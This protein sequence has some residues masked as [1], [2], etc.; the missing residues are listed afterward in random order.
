M[1]EE[2][3]RDLLIEI[4]TKLEIALTQQGDHETRIRA[5]ERTKWLAI[6]AAAAAGGAAGRLAG[7]L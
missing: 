3:I 2:S 4:K 6:G 5:L 7:L 1:T